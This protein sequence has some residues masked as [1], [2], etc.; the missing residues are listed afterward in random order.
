MVLDI[1]VLVRHGYDLSAFAPGVVFSGSVGLA[2]LFAF[3]AFVGFEATGLFSEEAR[4]PRRTIP[5]ATYIAIV[6]IGAFAAVTT[7]AI[8]MRIDRP[9]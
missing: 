6:A 3:N 4:N 5:R 7:V 8:V 2:F 1:A 9:R